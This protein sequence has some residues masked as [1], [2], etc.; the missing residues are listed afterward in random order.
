MS[1]LKFLRADSLGGIMCRWTVLEH[2]L[3]NNHD[4]AVVYESGLPMDSAAR[5]TLTCTEQ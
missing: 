1:C 5:L 2:N 4:A 3:L